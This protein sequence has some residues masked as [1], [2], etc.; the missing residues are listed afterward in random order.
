MISPL[1]DLIYFK[2]GD[3]RQFVAFFLLDMV[4]SMPDVFAGKQT[5]THGENHENDN[6]I[7]PMFNGTRK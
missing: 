7:Q 1:S 5:K 4:R 2:V 3:C 6:K